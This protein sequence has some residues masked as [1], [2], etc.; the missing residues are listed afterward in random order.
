MHKTHISLF[1]ISL[2]MR[3]THQH[4]HD[5][6]DVGISTGPSRSDRECCANLRTHTSLSLSLLSLSFS[7]SA[8][9]LIVAIVASVATAAAAAAAAAPV[10]VAAAA[11]AATAAAAASSAADSLMRSVANFS[12]CIVMSA[13]HEQSKHPRHV[14]HYAICMR[15]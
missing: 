11:A 1:L 9:Y 12:R 6:R 7:V 15:I 13:S 10:V 14:G 4:V 2:D 8:L 5:V 3:C